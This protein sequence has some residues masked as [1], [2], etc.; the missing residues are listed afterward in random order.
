MYVKLDDAEQSDQ[1]IE[2]KCAQYLKCSPNCS[3][4]IK[5]QI[6][7]PKHLHLSAFNVKI[8]NKNHVLKLPISQKL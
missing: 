6:E 2:Q 1:K 3:Q 4:N 7:D 8:S 5:A